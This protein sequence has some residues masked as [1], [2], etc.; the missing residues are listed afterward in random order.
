MR[1]CSAIIGRSW[2]EKLS[3]FIGSHTSNIL[4]VMSCPSDCDPPTQDQYVFTHDA[5]LESLTCGETQIPASELSG[6][7]EKLKEKDRE[8][9]RTGF[10]T[11][12][13]VCHTH[14]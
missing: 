12:F 8:S 5:V 4:Y 2:V 3:E 7:I 1:S 11:Q 6:A 9:G 10:E 14:E 13:H